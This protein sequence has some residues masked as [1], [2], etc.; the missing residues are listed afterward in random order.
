MTSKE[1]VMWPLAP[2]K[3]V[4]TLEKREGAGVST[5][6]DEDMAEPICTQHSRS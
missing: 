5:K 3:M 4:L 1:Y 2:E 6:L